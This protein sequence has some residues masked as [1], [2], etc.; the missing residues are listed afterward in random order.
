MKHPLAAI[1]IGEI[2]WDMLPTG[3]QLG[4]APTNFAYHIHAMGIPATAVSAVG[5][6]A[7]GDDIRAQ[8]AAWGLSTDFLAVHPEY[9]TGTVTVAL[10]AQGIPVYEIHNE[11]AWD[12]L[13]WTDALATLAPS[14]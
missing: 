6:D 11:V 1:G 12:H 5:A 9:P 2:L 7:P 3:R 4:G 10:D 8:V 14:P 13:A